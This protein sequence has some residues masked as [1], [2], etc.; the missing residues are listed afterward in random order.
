MFALPTRN[1]RER[2]RLE[3]DVCVCVCVCVRTVR[4]IGRES[5][6]VKILYERS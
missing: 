5:E 1:E 4:A 2:H 3:L 6:K